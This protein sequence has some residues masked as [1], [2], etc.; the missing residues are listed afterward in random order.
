MDVVKIGFCIS[1]IYNVVGLSFAA[2]A[3]LSPLLAAV[4]MPLSSVSVVLFA[5]LAVRVIA[6]R[7]RLG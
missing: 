4:L 2:R 5:T 6:R 1:F 3:M 7:L